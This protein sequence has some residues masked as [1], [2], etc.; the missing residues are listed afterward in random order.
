L[1]ERPRG[2]RCGHDPA[3]PRRFEPPPRHAPRP[4]ILQR[5]RA[6]VCGYYADPAALLPSLN[7]ANGS[8]RQQRSER[9]EAC[10]ALLGA[11][12]HYTDL[13]T[14][15][16]GIPRPNG[17]I[18]NL[19]VEQL[20]ERAGLGLRRA[21]RAL[22]DL[23]TA[24]VVLIQPLYRQQENGTYEGLAARKTLSR[25]LFAVFGLDRWLAHERRK[26]DER[27]QRA[28]KRQRRKAQAQ[29]RLAAGAARKPHR[30][31]P[32][33]PDHPGTG[34]TGA[35]AFFADVRRILGRGPPPAA[36]P[37]SPTA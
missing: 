6:A 37:P 32:S 11:L 26:A 15:R 2:N 24:G 1:A 28:L 8:E 17:W 31:P 35:S 34:L 13:A 12:V 30:R 36:A 33:A 3:N 7:A 9:R 4:K 27:R 20:A 22:H 10:L 29:L 18:E 16:V 25:H 19:S 14:L 21:E 23:V 5:L